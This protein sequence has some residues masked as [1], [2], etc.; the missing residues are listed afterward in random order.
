[1][2]RR[3]WLATLGAAGVTMVGT[4]AGAD[5]HAT[6]QEEKPR[7]D[8]PMRGPHAHFCGI[9]A[10]KHNAKLQF[11][12]QH[13]CTAHA[14]GAGHSASKDDPIFQCVLFDTCET[15]A[16]L[17][18][19]EYVISDVRYQ[20]LPEE[21]KKYWHPH[22]YEV[23]GGGL[24]ALGMPPEGERSFMKMLLTTW[25]KAW[26]T[27][28]D[29]ATAIPMG[30]PLLIWSLNGDGQVDEKLIAKRDADFD[31]STAEIRERR[32]GEFKLDVPKVAPPRSVDSIGR[33]WTNSGDD[34][35]TPLG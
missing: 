18:G 28:P 1:M 30:E 13:Y 3:E 32:R 16:K 34:K 31:V 33:R 35:P 10:A 29:T 14:P 5:E 27:W 7:L 9:H 21:E 4:A 17:L 22:A 23:L 20:A 24:V 25:G 11:I 26:H 15:N 2:D 12:A 8:G 6:K 19:V